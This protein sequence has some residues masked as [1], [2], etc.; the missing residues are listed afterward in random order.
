MHTDKYKAIIV[1]IIRSHL[2]NVTIILYGSRA[3]GD[4]SEGS[5]IDIALDTHKTID[6]HILSAIRGDLEDSQLP[7]YFDVVD[8]SRVSDHMKK[9]IKRDGVIW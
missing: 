7:I 2:P 6:D 9:E 3:R 1:P 8:L 4:E 5:D